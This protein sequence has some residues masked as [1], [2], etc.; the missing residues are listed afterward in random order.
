MKVI[1]AFHEPVVLIENR[2]PNL[3][4]EARFQFTEFTYAS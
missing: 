3:A 4:L 2:G 1:G